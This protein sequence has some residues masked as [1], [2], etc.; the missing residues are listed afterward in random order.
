L[1]G[2][3]LGT[4]A[5]IYLGYVGSMAMRALGYPMEYVFPWGTVVAALVTGLVFG[6]LSSGLPSRQA[7]RMNVVEALRY[8]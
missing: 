5:G 8:E 6:V 3:V 4:L 7:A 1:I 2:S